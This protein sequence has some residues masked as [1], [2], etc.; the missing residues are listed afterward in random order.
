MQKMKLDPFP[1]HIQKINS[2]WIK[3]LNINA[4]TIKPLEENIEVNIHDFVF[5][6]VFLDITPK[7]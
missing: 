5:S 3:D 4:K 7:V 6:S 1:T 2:Q